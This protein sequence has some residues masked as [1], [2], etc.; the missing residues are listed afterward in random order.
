MTGIVVGVSLSAGHSF[1]KSG[2]DRI[3]LLEGVGVEGDAHAGITVKH[4]SR[5]AHDPMQPN[6]RQV[7]LLHAELHDELRARGF[8]VSPGDMG[9]NLTTRGVDLLKLAKGTLL[10]LGPSAVLEVTGL[11]NP[12]WKWSS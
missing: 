2:C 8:T 6:L 5:V 9:E 3:R 4:R 11:R 7:H 12:L 10:R 1:S